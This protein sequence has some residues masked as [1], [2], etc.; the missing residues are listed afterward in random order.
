MLALEDLAWDMESHQNS[1]LI[2][3]AGKGD[4]KTSLVKSKTIFTI[5]HKPRRRHS[6]LDNKDASITLMC[7]GKLQI[8]PN[9]AVVQ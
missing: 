3:S 5:F 7:C 6:K 9:T 8:T 4:K 1:P 2:R